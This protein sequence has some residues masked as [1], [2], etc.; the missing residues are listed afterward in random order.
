MFKSYRAFSAA[1]CP[2][3]DL[4]SDLFSG[5]RGLGSQGWEAIRWEKEGSWQP[6]ASFDFRRFLE[7]SGCQP[8]KLCLRKSISHSLCVAHAFLGLVSQS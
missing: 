6:L 1:V 3:S 7:V 2:M 4:R 8:A 5:A